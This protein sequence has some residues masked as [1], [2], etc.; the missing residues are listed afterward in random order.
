MG[1]EEWWLMY[2]VRRTDEPLGKSGLTED[3]KAHLYALLE[4]KV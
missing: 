1:P 3:D 4:P 2:D